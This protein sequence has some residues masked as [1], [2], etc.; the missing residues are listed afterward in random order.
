MNGVHVGRSV[1]VS[2]TCFSESGCRRIVDDL[3]FLL[4][5]SVLAVELCD[6][7]SH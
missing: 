3:R 2:A 4:H 5:M 7:V 6:K 1:D